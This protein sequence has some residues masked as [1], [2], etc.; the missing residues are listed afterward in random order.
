MGFEHDLTRLETITTLL[1][2]A[3][4]LED[5]LVLYEEG[6]ALSRTCAAYLEAA[7]RRLQQTLQ[8]TP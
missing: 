5:A 8:T 1:D 2:Q 6:V 4:S 3:P 7:E